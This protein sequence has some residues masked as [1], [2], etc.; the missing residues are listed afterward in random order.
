M[1]RLAITGAPPVRTHSFPKWP[2]YGEDDKQALLLVLQSRNWG[3]YPSPNTY[4]RLFNERFAAFQGANHGIAAANGTVTLEVALKAGGLRPGDE[5]IVPAYTWIGTASGVLSAQGIPVFV[6]SDPSNYC[7][8][9]QAIEAAITPRTRAVIPV[10]L[11]MQLADMDAILAIAQKRNLLVIEDCAHVHGAQWKGR[12]A[13]SLGHFGSFSLQTSK[14]LTSGEGGI[15]ITSDASAAERCESLIN[16]GRPSTTDRY[17]Y[18]TLGLNYRMTEFQAALLLSQLAKLP[19]QTERR[20]ANAKLLAAKLRGV[21]GIRPLEWDP[22]ITRPAIYHYLLRYDPQAFAGVHRDLF[23]EA[24][25][26]EGIPAEGPF[27]EPLYRAPL[28]HFRRDDFAV[29]TGSQVDYLK[30]HCPVAEKAAYDESIWLHHPLLLGT[31][32]EINDIVEAI[33]RIQANA[34][35][36]ATLPRPERKPRF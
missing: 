12:G 6:D 1:G 18:R 31:E 15:I 8:N 17:K 35:E 3:G 33:S 13:G 5:V 32:K 20:L 29:F 27:Y 22:R 16:C 11:G 7:I 10:H 30:T 4:A 36:L 26:A 21:Q 25:R 14:I 34:A 2:E 28:W 9:P 19:E 23:L 24:L